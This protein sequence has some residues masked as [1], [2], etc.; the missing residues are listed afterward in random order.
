MKHGNIDEI[1]RLA[2]LIEEEMPLDEGAKALLSHIA[3]CRECYEKYLSAA[4]FASLTDE[5]GYIALSDIYGAQ[6]SESLAEAEAETVVSKAKRLAA[7][8]LVSVHRAGEAFTAFIKQI[9]RAGE[10]LRFEAPLAVGTRGAAGE[11]AS[12]TVKLEDSENEKTF[13]A[14]DPAAHTLLLQL[15]ARDFAGERVTAC[16]LFRNGERREVALERVGFLLKGVV[17]D[18][19]EE[20]FEL[21]IECGE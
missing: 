12:P 5:T 8:L 20:D 19:P 6:L 4:A 17:C 7:E 21:M 11:N 3:D 13:V 1:V 16:L 10:L 2:E 14:V 15:D 18:V 9:E